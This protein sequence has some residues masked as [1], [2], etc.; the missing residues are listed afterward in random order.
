MPAG[1]SVSRRLVSWRHS[2]QCQFCIE[3][4]R[5]QIACFWC[6]AAACPHLQ[7]KNIGKINTV[8]SDTGPDGLNHIHSASCLNQSWNEEYAY[9][10][11]Q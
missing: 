7:P 3:P 9:A 4:A 8:R 10:E 5:K 2:R 1:I 6:N 11:S